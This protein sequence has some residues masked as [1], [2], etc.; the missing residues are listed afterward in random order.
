MVSNVFE[1]WKNIMQHP[2]ARLDEKRDK[3]I[4]DRLRDGYTEQD[5]KDAI[6]GCALS[7]FHMGQNDHRQK[8]ND[9]TLICRDALHV[10]KFI[11]IL[12]AAQAQQVRAQEVLGG[13]VD[14]DA[15]R[16]RVV[17]LKRRI[18]MG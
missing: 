18:K 11:G 8:Y 16:E 12:E 7:D 6:D 3:L 17:E 10:D 2:R 9:I 15:A 13:E 14:K 5:V 4:R 1:H